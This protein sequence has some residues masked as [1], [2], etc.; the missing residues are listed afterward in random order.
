LA[1]TGSKKTKS[2]RSI[3]LVPEKTITCPIFG[4]ARKST[5]SP[6]HR[7]DPHAANV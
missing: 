6:K 2:S 7:H 3:Q 5:K 4:E 1:N